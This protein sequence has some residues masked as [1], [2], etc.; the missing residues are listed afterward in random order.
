[1]QDRLEQI[2]QLTKE[3][4]LFIYHSGHGVLYEG[5]SAMVLTKSPPEEEKKDPSA[6]M[7][8][9]AILFP[10]QKIFEKMV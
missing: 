10:M 7:K 1:M 8:K 6:D 5:A 2:S 9:P 4:L 3:T